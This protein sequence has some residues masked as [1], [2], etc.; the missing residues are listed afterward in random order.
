MIHTNMKG[1]RKECVSPEGATSSIK[2]NRSKTS[3]FLSGN[4]AKVAFHIALRNH[5]ALKYFLLCLLLL[6]AP[7]ILN[8]P[9]QYLPLR[10]PLPSLQRIKRLSFGHRQ[11]PGQRLF[12][13]PHRNLIPFLKIS[14]LIKDIK[15]SVTSG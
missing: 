2:S 3:C 4:T 7:C 1:T 8:L 13:N 12:R 9:V 10:T 14:F 5:I 15:L 6:P 11:S